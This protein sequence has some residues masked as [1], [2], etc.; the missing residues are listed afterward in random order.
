MPFCLLIKNFAKNDVLVD[1]VICITFINNLC[2]YL[3]IYIRTLKKFFWQ[4]G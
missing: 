1:N 3:N 4:I 2:T